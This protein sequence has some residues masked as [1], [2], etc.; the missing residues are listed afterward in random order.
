MPCSKQERTYCISYCVEL[1][2]H[3]QTVHTLA[4]SAGVFWRLLQ[5]GATHRLHHSR[6]PLLPQDPIRGGSHSQQAQPTMAVQGP[7]HSGYPFSPL[8]R[9]YNR[10]GK[11]RHTLGHLFQTSG[12]GLCHRERPTVLANGSPGV[13]SRPPVPRLL[14]RALVYTVQ[15]RFRG[16]H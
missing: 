5:S 13:Q 7:S 10:P 9:P 8:H 2:L 15:K 1:I 11:K 6:N 16:T 4:A 12:G 14:L 3:G